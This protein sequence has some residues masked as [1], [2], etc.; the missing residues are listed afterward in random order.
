MKANPEFISRDIAGETVLVPVGTAAKRCGGLIACNEV[1]SFIWHCLENE[2]S[3]EELCNAV[4]AEFE[5]SPE[6]AMADTKE[7]VGSLKELGAIIG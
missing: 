1:G 7:F 5:V 3:M 2:C 4:L 6:T